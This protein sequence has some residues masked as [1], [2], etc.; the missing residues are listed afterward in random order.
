M[1]ETFSTTE[2]E[3]CRHCGE[4]TR[5]EGLRGP[6]CLDTDL[7]LTGALEDVQHVADMLVSGEPV[8]LFDCRTGETVRPSARMLAAARAWFAPAV[9]RRLCRLCTLPVE[10]AAP[11]FLA[12]DAAEQFCPRCPDRV[13]RHLAAR[14]S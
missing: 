10:A 4:P 11:E 2:T 12:A 5:Y 8:E 3:A 1:T 14:T 13:R 9:A 6:I 7:V